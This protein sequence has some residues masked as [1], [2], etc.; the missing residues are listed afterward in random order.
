[1]NDPQVQELSPEEKLSCVL[2]VL[3]G[4]DSLSDAARSVGASV[5][6][7]VEWRQAVLA[8]SLLVLGQ[9]PGDSLLTRIDALIGEDGSL[10]QG[11]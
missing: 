9:A 10:P 3:H 5:Q 6:A 4:D 7:V 11:S 1:M 2:R 8:A